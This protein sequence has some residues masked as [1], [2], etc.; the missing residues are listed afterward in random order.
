MG[1]A[2]ASQ[3]RRG[4]QRAFAQNRLAA[5]ERP[6]RHPTPREEAVE[7]LLSFLEAAR[8]E[9]AAGWQ[10]ITVPYIGLEYT[11]REVA[12]IRAL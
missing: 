9:H 10:A 8:P 2:G 7:P 4:F 1:R 11:A 6:D 5:F 3:D 12:D